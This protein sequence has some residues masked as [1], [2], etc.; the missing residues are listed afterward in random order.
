MSCDT[1]VMLGLDQ[2]SALS[3]V[4]ITDGDDERPVSPVELHSLVAANAANSN[5]G[6]IFDTFDLV[7]LFADLI[8]DADENPYL[9]AVAF[10]LLTRCM[11]HRSSTPLFCCFTYSFVSKIS[12]EQALREEGLFVSGS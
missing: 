6:D 9:S 5:T 12:K 1:A 10:P 7:K 3:V 2:K 11:R 8:G 4:T